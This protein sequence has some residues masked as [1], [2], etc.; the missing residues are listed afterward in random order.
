MWKDGG[1]SDKNSLKT[2]KVGQQD[3]NFV[4]RLTTKDHKSHQSIG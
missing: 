3:D 4:T 2:Y 1:M